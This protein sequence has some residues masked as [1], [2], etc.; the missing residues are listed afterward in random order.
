MGHER[1]CAERYE[2][3]KQDLD[4]I[5][6]VG[7][8]TIAIMIVTLISTAGWSLKVQAD[9][10]RAAVNAVHQTSDETVRKLGAIE[11]PR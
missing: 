8:W 9:T 2:G 5:K 10:Q 6:R 3:I 4:L 1:L 11:A 7:G